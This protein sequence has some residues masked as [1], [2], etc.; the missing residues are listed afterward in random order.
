LALA[1]QRLQILFY[2][3]YL[4]LCIGELVVAQLEAFLQIGNLLAVKEVKDRPHHAADNYGHYRQ[5]CPIFRDDEPGGVQ[6]IEYRVGGHG[7]Y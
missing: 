1:L 6:S 5:G 3:L 7:L 4:S 2:P